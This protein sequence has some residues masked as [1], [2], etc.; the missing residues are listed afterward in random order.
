[1]KR[2]KRQYPYDFKTSFGFSTMSFSVSAAAIFMT[3]FFMQ[4][5]TDYSGI[6]MAIGKVGFAAAFGTVL[7]LIARIVDIVDDPLQAWIIDNAKDGRLGKYR[8]FAFANV[9]LVT[10]AMICIFSIPGF[11]K[12]NVVLLCI[13]VGFF[14]FLYEL[15]TAFSTSTPLL[16]KTTLDPA[17]RSKLSVLMRIWVIVILVPVY[18]YIPVVTVVDQKIGNIGKTFS[19]VCIVLMAILGVISFIGVLGLKEQP[20]KRAQSST[21]KEDE[22]LK[23]KE[24]AAMFIKNKPLL[25]HTAAALLSGLVFGLFSVVSVYFLKW[26]YAADLTTGVVDAV[27]YAEIYGVFVIAALIPNFITPFISNKLIKKSGSYARVAAGCFLFGVFVYVGLTVLYFTGILKVS[28]YIYVLFNFLSGMATG[29]AVIPQMLLWAECADYAEYTTGK[30]MSALINSVS[31]MLNKALNALSSV[32]AG[33]VLI[34]VGYSV[35]NETGNYAGDLTQLPRM[36][37]GFAIA[38]TIIPIVVLVLS[39]ILY[40]FRYPLTPEMQKKMIDELEERRGVTGEE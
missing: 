32:I 31:N 12:S 16:Q 22:K 30:K 6:D 27:K 13:W 1:M 21:G 23:V 35:N 8:K 40:R 25:I 3:T 39:Y 9:I 37:N 26:Y 11:I 36:I 5:L 4:Y 24:V 14:Y 10:L 7:L 28:P 38:L 17:L 15:G 19:L 20:E 34:A 33:A 2:G 18:F 29:T